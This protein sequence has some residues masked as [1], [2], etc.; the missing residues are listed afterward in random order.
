MGTIIQPSKVKVLRKSENVFVLI[1]ELE[2]KSVNGV[3]E[4]ML[5]NKSS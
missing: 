4:R 1:T 2:D 3:Y 5:T